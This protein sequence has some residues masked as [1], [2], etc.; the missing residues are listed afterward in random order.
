MQ[1]EPANS[2]GPKCLVLLSGGIDSAALA[3]FY[4]EQNYDVSAVHVTYGQPPAEREMHAATNVAAHYNISLQAI[5][6]EGGRVKDVGEIIGRN[7]ML[8]FLALS[9]SSLNAP[10]LIA[11]GIHSGTPYY[12]CSRA[13]LRDMQ[14]ILDG[15]CN[16]TAR[17][18]APFAEWSKN[19]IWSYCQTHNVPTD[20][21]YSC[22]SGGT[23][24]C[25]RCLTCQDLEALHAC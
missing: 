21:T 9:E 4:L 10:T 14:R 16:G 12:D 7:A 18:A 2:G 13:F 19:D 3:H 6:V 8:V 15:H 20:M 1:K 25:G 5:R 11:L 22:E 24:P 17:I 23:Q